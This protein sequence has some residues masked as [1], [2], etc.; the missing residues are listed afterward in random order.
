MKAG[1]FLRYH[2]AERGTPYEEGF[3]Y[4]TKVPER[5]G[6]LFKWSGPMVMDHCFVPLSAAFLDRSGRIIEIK[7]ME[8]EPYA[9]SP[10]RVYRSYIEPYMFVLEAPKGAFH[11]LGWG[12]G[13]ILEWDDSKVYKKE[14]PVIEKSGPVV[15]G[16][17]F[18]VVSLPSKGLDHDIWDVEGGKEEPDMKPEVQREILSRLY[19]GLK[20]AGFSSPE[21]WVAKVLIT[22]SC[23]TNQFDKDS[24]IDVNVFVD[25]NTLKEEE[26]FSGSR[27][28]KLEGKPNSD[29]YA[30]I[31]DVF[32]RDISGKPLFT[33]EH[34][35]N[36]FLSVGS[37]DMENFDSVYDLIDGKWVKPPFFAPKDFDPEVVFPEVYQKALDI[38][39]EFDIELGTIKR[40]SIKLE[41]IVRR[42]QEANEEDKALIKA[43][44]NTIIAKLNSEI[45]ELYSKYKDIHSKRKEVFSNDIDQLRDEYMKSKNWMPEA[46]LYKWLD[47]WRYLKLARELNAIWNNRDSDLLE[48]ILQIRKKLSSSFKLSNATQI[49]MTTNIFNTQNWSDIPG[50]E[51]K[52]VRLYNDFN[53]II[54]PYIAQMVIPIQGREDS[55][56]LALKAMLKVITEYAEI[57]KDTKLSVIDS[58]VDLNNKPYVYL[59]ASEAGVFYIWVDPNELESR[60]DSFSLNSINMEKSSN[61]K[62]DRFYITMTASSGVMPAGLQDFILKHG[63]YSSEYVINFPKSV[64]SNHLSSYVGLSKLSER[65]AAIVT[66]KSALVRK[67]AESRFDKIVV[68]SR[69]DEPINKANSILSKYGYRLTDQY[70]NNVNYKACA[71]TLN[72]YA[73]S[74]KASSVEEKEIKDR[75]DFIA[76]AID[77]SGI[78]G[79]TYKDSGWV[80]SCF[81]INDNMAVTC[82][83]VLLEGVDIKD[84]HTSDYSI[85]IKFGKERPIVAKIYDFDASLDLALLVF[86]PDLVSAA[87][88]PIVDSKDLRPGYPIYAVGSPEGLES[89]VSQG[90]VAS[91][92]REIGDVDKADS[93]FVNLEIHPGSSGGPILSYEKRAVVGVARGSIGSSEDNDWINYCISSHTLMKWLDGNGIPYKKAE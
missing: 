17:E 54:R 87:P 58:G 71:Y 53:N 12:P 57:R 90:I 11:E 77:A 49:G 72:G 76:D 43:K 34:L 8:P 88:L 82:H 27:L 4:V 45:K 16:Q 63:P 36:Y 1:G 19:R 84:V 66:A 80:G 37:L 86:D 51:D 3:R 81:R 18:S 31:K 52:E 55:A 56:E 10:S 23:T 30:Y 46:V 92:H 79:I 15:E 68:V 24:D 25:I 44:L 14:C 9:Q 75:A 41:E 13:D 20:S 73:L 7:D 69:R 70:Y 62:E 33:T 65:S 40:D 59:D 64:F 91:T 93:F 39:K 61:P 60:L 35:I 5:Y 89:I 38:A 48:K 42:L 32:I 47:K 28:G 85:R 78:V 83:H 50:V 6:L 2:M 74:K 26:D 22:G 67:A 21:K 29:I